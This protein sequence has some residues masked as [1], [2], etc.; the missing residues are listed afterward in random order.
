M[1]YDNGQFAPMDT[2]DD[3]REVYRLFVALGKGMPDEIGDR[4]RMGF[5]QGLIDASTC[6]FAGKAMRVEC[7]GAAEAYRLFVAVTGCLGVDVSRA[8][9]ALREV[10]RRRDDFLKATSDDRRLVICHS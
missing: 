8:A 5:L 3:R 2:L 6:G 9:L 4:L 7:R 10:V 1:R